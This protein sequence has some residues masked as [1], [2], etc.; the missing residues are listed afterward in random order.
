MKK[1]IKVFCVAQIC[2]GTIA[3]Y[4]G[5]IF[6]AALDNLK[7][8]LSAGEPLNPIEAIRYVTQCKSDFFLKYIGII[9]FLVV[10]LV[11]Y[12]IFSDKKGKILDT[13]VKRI[14]ERISI[15]VPA[16]SGQ[17]GSQRFMEFSEIEEIPEISIY[18]YKEGENPP[19]KG[20]VVLGIL[21]KKI[22]DIHVSDKILY[23]SADRHVL[24]NGATRSGKTRRIILQSIWLT[25]L[26][27]ENILVNDPKGELWTYTS[28]FAKEQGYEVVTIDFRSPD[29]GNRHNYLDE[30]V[31]AV[32]RNDIGEA[33]DLTWDLVAVLVGEPKGEKIWHD[34]ECAAIAAVIMIVVMDA[35]EAYQNLT[36]VY[37]FLFNMAK[38]GEFG[39]MPISIYLERLPEKHPARAV[40]AMAEIAHVRTRGSFFS[41]A[42]G[43][44][45]H[46]TSPKIAD[47][48]S[49]TDY[50]F[51]NMV[52]KKTIVYLILPDEKTTLYGLGSMYIMQHYIYMVKAANRNGGRCPIDW[53][54]FLDE[55]GNM[56]YIPPMP[57]YL[58]VGA[59]RGLRFLL[60]LQDFQQLKNRYKEEY[61]V[62]KNNSE[63]WVYMKGT[64]GDTLKEFSAR[65]GDYTVQTNSS[66]FSVNG[67]NQESFSASLASRPLLK[68]EEVGLIGYPYSLISI[69]GQHPLMGIAPDISFYYANK[70]LGLGDKEHNQNITIERNSGREA[71]RVQDINLWGIWNDYQPMEEEEVEEYEDYGNLEEKRSFLE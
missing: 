2:L 35:P 41:S 9:E 20:G 3:L 37:Y 38:P 43:S 14:T 56:P 18:E 46:F 71:R 12:L 54:Y 59:G 1:K 11:L 22:P 15:P 30:I 65:L 19:P 51:K 68:P 69:A 61:S 62:I 28:P 42:L 63:I 26:A 67:R 24:L 66:N 50:V 57:Q 10:L 58:S 36:N 53:W 21:D 70:E 55:F 48:T 16:G 27:G 33:I 44:L 23:M 52:D 5:T 47:M 49:A 60:A 13:G 31:Q 17:Y 7:K 45:K 64:D 34:G 29:K 39:N 8:G 32:K 25:I 40:F 4:L 6:L